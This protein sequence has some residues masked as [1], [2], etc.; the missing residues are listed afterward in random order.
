MRK[1]FK[2][3]PADLK[4]AFG[5]S[6]K[7][8]CYKVGF[9]FKKY[10]PKEIVRRSGSLYLDLNLANRRQLINAGVKKGNIYDCT[11]CTVCNSR[12]HSYR[13]DGEKSGRMLSLMMMKDE[14]VKQ[15]KRL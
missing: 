10:F 8:C 15:G 13:R 1:N 7:P 12:F 11:I 14:K 4:I 9:E 3:N 2:T 5:P 6:I